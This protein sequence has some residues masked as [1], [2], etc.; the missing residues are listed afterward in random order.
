MEK[1]QQDGLMISKFVFF[2]G[3]NKFLQIFFSR[4]IFHLVDLGEVGAWTYMGK[5]TDS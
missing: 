1:F 3:G 2:V 5:R 4:K